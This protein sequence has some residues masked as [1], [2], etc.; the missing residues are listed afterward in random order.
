M[1]VEITRVGKTSLILETPVMNA[2]GTFGFGATYKE[3]VNIEKLGAMVTNPISYEP[4][5]AA[6]GTRVIP[7]DSAI[8]LHTGLPNAGL[9][10]VLRQERN[11][12]A[13]LPVPVIVHLIATTDDQVRKAIAR[14][15]E[16]ET[17]NAVELG[18]RDDM[19]WQEASRLVN[20]A[21]TKTEK[22]VLVRLPMGDAFE[23]A[24]PVADAGAS[25]LVIA[26][27]PRGT[28]RDPRTGKLVSG[29]IY[30][31]VVK[32]MVLNMV[33]QIARRIDIPIIGAGGIHTPQDARDYLEAGAV[34][35]QVDSVIWRSP[36]ELEV[37]ARDL[38]GYIVTR[39][40]DA[41][42]DEWHRGMGD[43]EKELY[44]Q[45]RRGNAESDT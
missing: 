35:V 4:R 17:V 28:A 6:R 30:G 20:A 9:N 40:S 2:A 5:R 42:P 10:K 41:F 3:I 29:R 1:A 27:P 21:V 44:E 36:P 7:L 34:A 26:A 25:T 13:V 37:I 23:I 18:L 24:E 15:D 38:G 8:L 33:G 45:M 16:E 14:L 32:P 22:P 11:L 39:A 19:T 12:W 31:P 43:T